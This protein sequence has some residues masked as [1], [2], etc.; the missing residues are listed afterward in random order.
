MDDRRGLKAAAVPRLLRVKRRGADAR[1]S[2][3]Q[4]VPVLVIMYV[5]TTLA[6]AL[7]QQPPAVT[8]RRANLP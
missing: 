5:S 1:V 4:R 3:L 8:H 2:N 7:R 6:G